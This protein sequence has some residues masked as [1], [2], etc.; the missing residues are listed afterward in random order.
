MDDDWNKSWC[1]DDWKQFASSA[2]H[3]AEV[4]EILLPFWEKDEMYD[5]LDEF[6][7]AFQPVA[8]TIKFVEWKTKVSGG[9]V[10]GWKPGDS[11]QETM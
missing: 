6:M 4:K 2:S 7:T 1:L 10:P 3:L 8:E 11:F 5:F 9:F